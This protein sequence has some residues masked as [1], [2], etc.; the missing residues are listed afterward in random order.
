MINI[1]KKITEELCQEVIDFYK[2][3]PMSL[4]TVCDKFDLCTPTVSKILN[5]K[6]V[7]RWDKFLIYSPNFQEN[8][9]SEINTERKAYFLGLLLTDG[10][11]FDKYKSKTHPPNIN[12][13]L[14]AEDVY[15]LD[16]LRSELCVNKKISQDGRGCFQ[17][18]VFSKHMADD[19]SRYGVVPN[20]SLTVQFPRNLPSDLYR[21]FIRGVFDGDGSVSFYA[22]P[23]RKV[24][25]KAIRFCSGSH[26]F[27]IDLIS[28]LELD[29]GLSSLN[30][31]QEKTNLWSVAYRSNKD[32]ENII[33][34]LYNDATI[35]MRRK[36][37]KC[38]LILNELRKYRDN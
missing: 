18:V 24:H 31:Y 21:H 9:F 25:T 5:K 27:L 13:T 19:L 12:L 26:Q 11:I 22:R 32:L 20:K 35:Y 37:E 33:P 30:T 28:F 1:G 23:N 14:Q 4:D 8:Y 38:D 7:P 16:A 10:N 15:I 36:K 3:M 2:T 34:Y 6:S 29:A 17:F